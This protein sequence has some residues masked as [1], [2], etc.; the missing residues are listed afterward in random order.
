MTVF[1]V[2]SD[3]CCFDCNVA[4]QAAAEDRDLSIIL[5]AW[6]W[7]CLGSQGADG[8]QVWQLYQ[9]Y[10]TNQVKAVDT[11]L[12]QLSKQKS[13]KISRYPCRT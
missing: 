8:Y 7:F 3:V 6:R 5:V 11:V 12:T 4:L 2:G 10:N 1:C 9:G 13:G